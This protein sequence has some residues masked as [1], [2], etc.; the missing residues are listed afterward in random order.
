MVFV[1]AV[2][3]CSLAQAQGL[4]HIAGRDFSLTDF[5]LIGGTELVGSAAYTANGLTANTLRVVGTAYL[6]ASIHF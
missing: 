3:L 5:S 1:I 4:T 2:A 6:I